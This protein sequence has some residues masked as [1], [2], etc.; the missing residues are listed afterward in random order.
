MIIDLGNINSS[1]ELQLKLKTA[2]GFADD[3]GMNWESF[4]KHLSLVEVDLP[5]EIILRNWKSLERDFPS[6]AE[7][8]KEK[9]SDFNRGSLESEIEIEQVY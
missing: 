6:E 3:Y 7:L 8:F 9:I 4:G 5:F 1:Q 2:F